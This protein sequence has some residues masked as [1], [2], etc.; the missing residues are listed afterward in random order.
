MCSTCVLLLQ[1]TVV[2]SA[3]STA[4]S[5]DPRKAVLEPPLLLTGQGASLVSA[6]QV[7]HKPDTGQ[8]L[9]V[10]PWHR[11]YCLLKGE[12][13]HEAGNTGNSVTNIVVCPS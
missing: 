7:R 12:R 11:M 4:Y 3:S 10:Q 1:V 5:H 8:S 2:L 9:P 6:V 13:K